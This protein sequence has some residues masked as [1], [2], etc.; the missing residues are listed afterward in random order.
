MPRPSTPASAAERVLAELTRA[1]R[2]EQGLEDGELQDLR[3]FK[4]RRAK[5]PAILHIKPQNRRAV[6]EDISVGGCKLHVNSHGISVGST[7]VVEIPGQKMVLDGRVCWVRFSEI[8]VDF[9]YGEESRLLR[10]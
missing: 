6:V 2:V 10:E 9:Q 1:I 4:R 5:W 3:R 8:G 7:V